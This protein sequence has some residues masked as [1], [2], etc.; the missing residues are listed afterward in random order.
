M[1]ATPLARATIR[2]LAVRVR[3]VWWSAGQIL[4]VLAPPGDRMP[5]WASPARQ[6]VRPGRAE[7]SRG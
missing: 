3:I 6:V 5:V 7:R 2:P 1:V 4:G